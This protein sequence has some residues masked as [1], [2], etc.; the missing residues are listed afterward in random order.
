MPPPKKKTQTCVCVCVCVVNHLR[1]H[2]KRPH[3]G[4]INTSVPYGGPRTERFK[5]RVE[6]SFQS[7]H[8]TSLGYLLTRS[9]PG[10][11]RKTPANEGARKAAGIWGERYTSLDNRIGVHNV[12]ATNINGVCAVSSLGLPD[13]LEQLHHVGAVQGRRPRRPDR[14]P[15]PVLVAVRLRLRRAAGWTSCRA[16]SCRAMC[17]RAG[18]R[19]FNR[20]VE[21]GEGEEEA[22][23][24]TSSC[25]N[26]SKA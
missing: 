24:A 10:T 22:L 3:L 7:R 8:V 23:R 25:A 19:G 5:C 9:Y 17:S 20:R 14:S 15:N 16:M 21:C 18:E 1:M 6:N 2:D 12:D 4:N 13:L 26:A 11:C